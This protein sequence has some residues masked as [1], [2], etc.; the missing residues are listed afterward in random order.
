MG[1]FD[2][3]KG[4]P[5]EKILAREILPGQRDFGSKDLILMLRNATASP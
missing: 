5:T 1:L 3:F 2:L 4:S